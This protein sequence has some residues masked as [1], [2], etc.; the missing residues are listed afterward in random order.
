MRSALFALIVVSPLSA[1]PLFVEEAGFTH[2]YAGGWEHF[3]GGGV[4]AFDCNNDGLP[5]LAMAGGENPV[6]LAIN[7]SPP[8]G[9]LAFE[10]QDIELTG[11]TGLWPLDIDGDGTTDLAVLRAGQNVL[12][13][14]DGACGFTNAN[15]AWGFD[16]GTRWSTAFS[17]TWIEGAPV[18]AIGNYV[19][20]DDPDGPFGACDVNELHRWTGTRFAAELLEPGFCP[21]SMLISDATRSGT[22]TLRLSNDRHYYVRGGSEQM[23]TLDTPPRLLGE[24]DGW[25]THLLWGMGIASRDLD[26]DGVAEIMLTSMGDQR[27]QL[28]EGGHAWADA[29]FARG[30]AS[31][32]PYTGGDGRPST[33]WH[34]E[35]ADVNNDGRDDLFIA[36]GN[37]DQMPGLAHDDPDNL[38]IQ[39]P[40]GTF[41][42]VGAEAG[43]A[44]LA[45]GRGAALIDLNADGLLDLVVVNRRAPA[46][47]YRNVSVGTGHWL[48]LD[49]SQP[50]PNSAAVGGFIELAAGG[51]TQWREI[52]VGGG[53]GGG[54][55]A[56]HHFGLG[57]EE[58]ARVRLHWPD[59]EIGNWQS[60]AAGA[61][62][63]ITR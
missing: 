3:V 30:T 24:A 57:E 52:T 45:R 29:P 26:G 62:H 18:L 13:R 5:E 37:V 19:D 38:L 54:Q 9:G 44:S 59:G 34:A 28:N 2:I 60:L 43:I 42:E 40:D 1:E 14:G 15:E 58:T 11:V 50:G 25:R 48:A 4:A 63:A 31:Q 6:T 20:R 12:L 32:R 41:I 7:R 36:K 27:L 8:G 46:L 17:A 10:T 56:P 33:G 23:W 61:V 53:H 47:I 39:Q 16:G 35:F 21:L 22:A 55:S 49:I 51:R